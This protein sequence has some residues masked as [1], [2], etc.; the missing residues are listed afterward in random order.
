MAKRLY[1][2]IGICMFFLFVLASSF[3]KSQNNQSPTNLVSGQWQSALLRSDGKVVLNGVEAYCTKSNCNGT[4]YVFI[5]FVNTNNYQV[6]L[7]W[8]DGIYFN[9]VWNYSQNPNPKQFVI[10][11][12]ATAEGTCNGDIKL[13]VTVNSLVNDPSPNKHFSVTGLKVTQ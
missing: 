12:G 9:G 7:E 13:K 5:K 10:A 2:Q 3:C 8:I 6:K 1:S 11:A 4:E